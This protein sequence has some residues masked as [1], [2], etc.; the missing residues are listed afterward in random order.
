M[1]ASVSADI[2]Q[3]KHCVVRSMRERVALHDIQSCKDSPRPAEIGTIPRPA[4]RLDS[5]PRNY[6]LHKNVLL[7]RAHLEIP[8]EY[9]SMI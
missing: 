7:A 4:Y 3:D 6:E 2:R 8:L 9:L 1:Q 5:S